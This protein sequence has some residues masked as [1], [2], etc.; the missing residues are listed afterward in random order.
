MQNEID[1]DIHQLALALAK[2]TTYVIDR[3]DTDDPSAK[4]QILVKGVFAGASCGS[5]VECAKEQ[6]S[7]AYK[8]ISCEEIADILRRGE[9]GKR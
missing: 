7:L 5:L 3:F 9:E 1:R 2:F 4:T 6:R 8:Y